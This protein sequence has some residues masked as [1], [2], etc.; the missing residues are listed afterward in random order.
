MRNTSQRSFYKLAKF[1]SAYLK[2]DDFES[3]IDI[4]LCTYADYNSWVE[5]EEGTKIR[6]NF[7]DHENGTFFHSFYGYLQKM[8]EI[9]DLQK[10][11]EAQVPLI[12]LKIFNVEIDLLLCAKYNSA[13]DLCDSEDT[14]SKKSLNSIQGLECTLTLEKIAN[15]LLPA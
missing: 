8:K 7:L 4:V 14:A 1:G 12:K 15:G 9:S 5:N 13:K 2:T 6:M 3:D 11:E 10:I